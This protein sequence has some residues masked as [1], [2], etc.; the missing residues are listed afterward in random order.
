MYFQTFF[1]TARIYCFINAISRLQNF[2]KINEKTAKRKLPKLPCITA[3]IANILGF[4]IKNKKYMPFNTNQHQSNCSKRLCKNN[5]MML[6]NISVY[7]KFQLP[8]LRLIYYFG[9]YYTIIKLLLLL[10]LC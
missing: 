7:K 10:S 3:F 8:K 9:F 5:A 6:I 2:F 4:L 1:N